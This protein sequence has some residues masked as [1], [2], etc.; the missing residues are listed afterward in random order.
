MPRRAKKSY[1]HGNL[2]RALLDAGLAA[3]TEDGPER[4]TLRDVARR[5]GVSPAAPYRHFADKE[6]LLAAVVAESAARLGEVMQAAVAG[7]EDPL[8]RF[9]RTGIAYVR[10]AAERPAHFRAMTNPPAVER[11]ATFLY[12][13]SRRRDGFGRGVASAA[14]RRREDVTIVI[15][16]YTRVASLMRGSLER[17]LKALRIEYADVLLLGW[18]NHAPP[19]RILDAAADLVAAGKARHIMISGHQRPLFPELAPDPRYGAFMVRY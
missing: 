12:W 9:R 5:A 15:Q 1:H 6:A 14:A 11:G 13:G 2:R 16:T 8:D 4:F 10:F 18:W 17:A 7:T 19:A 3:I